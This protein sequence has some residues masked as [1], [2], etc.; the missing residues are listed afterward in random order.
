MRKKII[1]NYVMQH[2]QKNP[3]IGRVEL[4]KAAGI[5]ETEARFYCRVYAEMNKGIH[6][7]SKGVALF[8]IHYPMHDRACMNV[9]AQFLKDFKPD[10][11]VYGGDQMQL[12]TI[13]AFNIRKPKLVEG[14][15]IKKEFNGFQRDILDRFEGIVSKKCKKFFMIGNHEYR[16]ERLIE[17]LP[18]YEGFIEL[19]NN[20]KLENYTM[21]PFN[22][23]FNIG[24]MHFA[25]GWYWNKYFSEKTLRVAQKMIF[26]GHVHT[27]QVHTAITPAYALPKQ[28]VGVGCLCNTN[29]EYME[30]KPNYWVHQ[31][32]FWYMM[33]DSTFTYYTP[34]IINGRCVI[35]GK[36]Y[37]GNEDNWSGA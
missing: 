21:I 23:M 12:D 22:D 30:D 16:I 20:L 13:S 5:P 37:D 19:K 35:N 28:A 8:D 29:P 2:I 7:K 15:R 34:M 4:S 6:L 33:D 31:F 14:K 24:G 27:A 11:L 9:I 3:Q 25:H 17:R 1:P 26:V 32:L 18:Q 36:L 10:Y